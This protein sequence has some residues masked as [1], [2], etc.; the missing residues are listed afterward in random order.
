MKKPV[1]ASEIGGL[2]E[3]VDNE[4]TGI[5]CKP[6]ADDFRHNLQ[7]LISGKLDTGLMKKNGYDHVV[8]HFNRDLWRSRMRE[9]FS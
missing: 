7:K 1:L 5:L 6:T 4:V 9:F 3:I 2:V 8:K